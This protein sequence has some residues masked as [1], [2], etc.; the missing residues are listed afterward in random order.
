M[1]KVAATIKDIAKL[2]GLGLATI[3][4]YLNGGNVREQNRVKIEQAIE[5]LHFEVNEVA[6]G[7]K[8]NRTKLIGIIIPELNNIFCSEII[9]EIEDILR[10]QGYAIML[11]DCRSDEQRE[12]EAVEFLK[13]RRVDGVI[14]MPSGNSGKAFKV[15][16]K[17]QIPIVCIDRR[18]KDLHCDCVLV[19]NYS[20]TK[21]AVE[22]LLEHG[23]QKIGMLAGPK[24]IY[25]TVERLRGYQEA[26]LSRGADRER[27]PVVHSDYTIQGGTRGFLELRKKHPDI[28][29]VV[30]SNYELM[31]GTIIAANELGIHIPE[32]LSVVG[33]DN[34]EFAKACMPK[35]D[36]VLQPTKEIATEA[37][38]LILER[39]QEKE[40]TEMKE[41]I[42]TAEIVR[43]R[44]IKTVL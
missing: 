4:S 23:H 3:S 9:T 33:Y 12:Y 29:A 35:L 28:T 25:T 14:V 16:Q 13:K 18:L 22:I 2:T 24:E 37:A 34:L 43:G 31:V 42:L 44:S 8:T 41:V 38:R 6:R 36:V 21:K 20:C 1:T 15:L 7:L 26:V 39:L 27:M 17:E 5:E 40:D 11:C 10:N 32:E 19:D 30:V